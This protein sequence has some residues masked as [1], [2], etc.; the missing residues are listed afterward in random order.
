M[1][2][3]RSHASRAAI[4]V[5][6]GLALLAGVATVFAT[7]SGADVSTV[8]MDSS[9]TAWDQNEAGLAPASVGSSDFGQIFKTQLDGQIY[10][11]PIIAAGTVVV[12]TENDKVYG[13]D[14]TTGAVN[15]T[16]DV[17]PYWPVATIGCGDLTP[18]IGVTST[19]VVDPAT[20]TVYLTAKV[21]DGADAQHPHWYMHALDAATGVERSGWP[22]VIAGSPSNDPTATFNP[23][24]AAQRPGLLLMNGVVYAGFASHCDIGPYRG[25]VVGVSTSTAKLTSMWATEV[26]QSNSGA[27]IWQSGG[28]LVSD[29]DGRI[30]FATGNGI[31]PPPAPGT[32]PPGTLA[33]SVVRL[34]VNADSSLSA[35]D[36]FSPSNAPTLD[37]NDTD[38]ASGGPVALPPSFGAG[39]GHPHLLVQAGKDGRVFLLDRDHLGGRSQGPNSTDDVVGVTG[40]FKGQWGHP[41]VWGGDGGYVYVIGNGGPL[42]ALKYGV[43]G[44]GVPALSAA[45]NTSSNFSYTTG[46][47]VVTSTGTTSGSALVWIETVTGPSGTGGTL[48][49]FN[50][51]PAASGLL[52]QVYSAPIGTASKF[53]APATDGGHVYVGTRDGIVMSFGRP[54]QAALTGGA[55]SLGS[56]PVGTTA[57]ATATL[58]AT[59]TVTITGL[60]TTTPF[61]VT[62][63]TLPVTLTS[64]QQLPVLVSVTP[65]A[66]GPVS[67]VLTASTDSGSFGFSLDATGTQPGL[68]ANPSPLT[69]LSRPTGSA[70]TANVQ[71][72]NTGTTAETVSAVTGPALPFTAAGLPAT[73][74]TLAPGASVAITVTY[75]P[76]VAGTQSSSITVSSTSGTLTIPLSGTAVSGQG[77]LV[78]SPASTAFGNVAQGSVKTLTFDL[79]NTGNLPVTITKAKAPAGDFS[80]ATPLAEGLVIGVGQV[81]HQAVS[82]APSSL[83]PQTA[84][85]EVTGDDGQSAQLEGL[86]GTGT[87]ASN[88][89]PAPS[90]GTWSINGT[91]TLPT[92]GG[93]QLTAAVP[94]SAGT[95]FYTTAVASD[96]L[97]AD[98][99]AQ[100]GPG[101]GGNG[102][103]FALLDATKAAP[104]GVGAP[105]GGLGFSGLTGEALAL[106]TYWNA[107]SNSN[108]YVAMAAGPGSGLDNLTYTNVAQV[109]TPLTTGTH[110]VAVTISGGHFKASIDGTPLI[111]STVVLPPKVF[112]GFTAGTG[113][114]ADAHAVSN[115]AITTT[116]P[117]VNKPLVATPPTVDFG[118]VA[119]GA[120]KTVLIQLANTG[121]APETVSAVGSPSAP[122]TASAP[123]VGTTIAAGSSVSMPVTFAPTGATVV[124]SSVSVTSTGGTVTV[125]LAGTAVATLPVFSDPTWTKNG[126]ANVSG[127][128]A[129]LTTDGQKFAAGD[130]VNSHPVLASGLHA[131][132]TVRIAGT[133]TTGADGLTLAFLDPATTT[134]KSLGATGG[135]LG[136]AGLS[137]TFI[138]LQTYPNAGINSY[139]A[140]FVGHSQAGSATLTS[141]GSSTAISPLRTGTHTVDVTVTSTGHLIAMIDGKASFNVA[142]TLPSHVLVA[143]TAGV[144][145]FTDTHAV[146]NATITYNAG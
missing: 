91:S 48:R 67:A 130:L 142:V 95:A 123:A 66:A 68:S 126:T 84:S 102:L 25:Y 101:T 120:T 94:Q 131:T 39:T 36:F 89:L 97:Q 41:A 24:T 56:T 141:L 81:V 70:A 49:A 27:G 35:A 34:Q 121:T 110:N 11:Q 71:V 72:T 127:G 118:P 50:A 109:P 136:V 99:T 138:A 85:Y 30:L 75:S 54:A 114:N 108:N 79:S 55:V 1:Q 8:S 16:R 44:A 59:K 113:A 29:G 98:F 74:S 21:N 52:T 62:P 105:G 90:A 32:S 37:L 31:S 139:N 106:G 53:A 51:V 63:P 132:F 107:S 82:F 73:G 69:F 145:H 65:A 20:Q 42:E 22:V 2:P 144:G 116:A 133:G 6:A 128:T 143:F 88:V 103:T 15:W 61:A 77:H 47:P 137:G 135:G 64:G 26:G 119:A 18:N 87:G 43:T 134:A 140:A 45:G 80:S 58:T 12:A 3:G 28:G 60:S 38:L 92:G 46:S 7:H 76:T 10:A 14:A 146:S 23:Y 17:G 57:H 4:S 112:V 86:T 104:S 117:L 5:I 9:R 40:P 78:L 93:L 83:G 115:V 129:T 124:S 125:P 96:G 19:P 33:E 13:L 100:L 111:D 122:F